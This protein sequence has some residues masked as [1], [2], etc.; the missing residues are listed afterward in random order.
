[1]D[2]SLPRPK[3]PQMW[4]NFG[5]AIFFSPRVALKFYFLSFFHF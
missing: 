4:G 5:Q 2:K 1:M 3:L